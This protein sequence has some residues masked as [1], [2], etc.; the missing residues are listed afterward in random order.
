MFTLIVED[1]ELK[2]LLDFNFE[3]LR[4]EAHEEGYAVR[5]HLNRE[6]CKGHFT[7]GIT[8]AEQFSVRIAG[9]HIYLTGNIAIPY[10][11]TSL[12]YIEDNME[13]LLVD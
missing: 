12:F 1:L 13:E 4:Q 2:H 3:E 10:H 8:R 7:F 9:D 5:L 11:Q 6:H